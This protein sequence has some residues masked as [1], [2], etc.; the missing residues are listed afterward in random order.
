MATYRCYIESLVSLK[1]FDEALQNL[2]SLDAVYRD[3]QADAEI[4]IRN[5]LR[6]PYLMVK[7]GK[8]DEAIKLTHDVLAE[9]ESS[10]S[11]FAIGEASY[12]A[13]I[14]Y[15]ALAEWDAAKSDQHAAKSIGL[16]KTAL[17]HKYDDCD[18][19]E[20]DF[21]EDPDFDAI[22]SHREFPQ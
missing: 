16:L 2:D 11:S 9:A 17:G 20:L 19:R 8:S 3:H 21:R 22:R 4:P 7:L 1:R 14:V 15:A 10:G 18:V 13:A 12:F 5:R 6:R